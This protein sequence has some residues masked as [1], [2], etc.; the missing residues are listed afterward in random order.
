MRRFLSLAIVC[1]LAILGHAQVKSPKYDKV[2]KRFEKGKFESA[3]ESAE[4]LMDNDK[5]RKHPEPY[6]WASMC[7]YEIYKGDDESVK[8]RVK[9]PMR[10]A[11]KYAGKAVSKDKDGDFIEANIEFIQTMK[12]EGMEVARSYEQEENYRKTVYTYK[13]LL[14]IDPED[15]FLLFYKGVADI[16]MNSYYEAERAIAESFP[17]LEKKYSNLDYVPDPITAPPL[18]E[19][20]VYY[21]NHLTENALKDSA[22]QIAGMARVFFPLDDNIKEIYNGLQ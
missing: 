10:N 9:S 16:K 3:L 14:K 13:Q 18:K 4:A 22:K 5:H 15:P 11:L 6:L 1:H 12:R 17:K 20:V 8:E 21:M 7:Y 2:A 19:N